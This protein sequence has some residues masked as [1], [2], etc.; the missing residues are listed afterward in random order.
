MKLENVKKQAIKEFE[1]KNLPTPEADQTCTDFLKALKV[2]KVTKPAYIKPH[3]NG[4][5]L[6]WYDEIVAKLRFTEITIT[7]DGQIQPSKV[8]HIATIPDCIDWLKNKLNRHP[9]ADMEAYACLDA[10]AILAERKGCRSELVGIYS[11]E[12]AEYL[13]AILPNNPHDTINS[14]EAYRLIHMDSCLGPSLIQ[15]VN[16]PF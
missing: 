14:P 2:E 16:Q 3:K 11:K 13:M 1:R 5:V 6:G 12:G 4:Y 10:W 9:Y 8:K 7:N 15:T